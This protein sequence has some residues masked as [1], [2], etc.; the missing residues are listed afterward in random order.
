VFGIF[1]VAVAAPRADS[2]RFASTPSLTPASGGG[3]LWASSVACDDP[4]ALIGARVAF[5]LDFDL[6]GAP[7]AVDTLGVSPADCAGESGDVVTISL[8]RVLRPAHPALLRA[9]LLD[10]SDTSSDAPA[11]SHAALTAG[12]GSLLA[13]ARYCARPQNGEP[14]WIELRNNTG[15]RIPLEK[16]LLDGRAL[17]SVSLALG[18]GGEI[19][20]SPDTAELR[21]WRPAARP[22]MLSSW[23]NLRNAGDTIRLSLAGGPVLDSVIYPLSGAYPREACVSLESEEAEAAAH[24][25][26]LALP[27]PARWRP[28]RSDFSIEV[29][30]PAAGRYDLRVFDLDGRALCTLARGA[31]G[32][33]T[34]ALPG[35]G[36]ADLE[37]R[38]GTFLLH[39]DPRGSPGVRRTFAIVP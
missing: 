8:R 20:A 39:L 12:P 34:F 32:P 16:A 33:A 38:R 2:L 31:T 24:G 25:F 4:P 18:A 36:C 21:L 26:A 6:D 17:K 22:V 29:R 15:F 30:A 11:D 14:E 19:A 1:A 28:R 5:A 7:D 9:A 23:T 35:S 37:T 10:P 13:I 27:Q 3:V